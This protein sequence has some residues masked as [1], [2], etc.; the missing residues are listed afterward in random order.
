MATTTWFAAGPCLRGYAREDHVVVRLWSDERG[1]QVRRAS[2]MASSGRAERRL[3]RLLVGERRRP[4]RSGYLA[5]DAVGD[6]LAEEVASALDRTQGWRDWADWLWRRGDPRGTRIELGEAL[7]AAAGTAREA[8]LQAE[9]AAFDRERGGRHAALERASAVHQ[10]A[11]DP[12]PCLGLRYGQLVDF[13]GPVAFGR[14]LAEGLVTLAR[15]HTVIH[16]GPSLARLCDTIEL[17]LLRSVVELELGLERSL[18]DEEAARV[19]EAIALWLP[20]LRELIVRSPAGRYGVVAEPRSLTSLGALLVRQRGHVPRRALTRL[21]LD[22]DA[23]AGWRPGILEELGGALVGSGLERVRLCGPAWPPGFVDAMRDANV[24]A[25]ELALVEARGR[26]SARA[27]VGGGRARVDTIVP[28]PS[29]DAPLEDPQVAVWSDWLQSQGEVVGELAQVLIEAGERTTARVAVLRDEIARR[30]T[31]G[32]PEAL[33]L[34]WRG[35]L[36]AHARVHAERSA[37]PLAMIERLV[38]SPASSRLA[39]LRI[40]GMSGR[41]LAQPLLRLSPWLQGLER[42]DLEGRYTLADLLEAWPRLGA[43]RVG[44]LDL[45]GMPRTPHACLR[46]LAFAIVDESSRELRGAFA[47]LGAAW[48][49]LLTKLTIDVGPGR[50]GKPLDLSRLELPSAAI[51]VVLGRPRECDC[52]ELLRWTQT[53]ATRVELPELRWPRWYGE[54]RSGSLR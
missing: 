36:I 50:R 17:G 38:T 5:A 20:N 16:D 49:P 31:T 3:Q 13:R 9:I 12:A 29:L 39:S 19:F 43:L 48:L 23:A 25:H 54:G 37:A 4:A 53:R 47:R 10:R 26:S 52:A 22:L 51:V 6:V 1:A 42:L 8:V 44:A 40:T 46:E 27:S 11:G 41:E 14:E 2:C 28:A 15:L 35:P 7:V 21:E 33:E 18:A 32:Q 45:A 30:L 34:D 24:G